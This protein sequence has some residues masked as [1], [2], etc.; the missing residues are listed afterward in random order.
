MLGCSFKITYHMSCMEFNSNYNSAK[1]SILVTV[2][3][4]FI[5]LFP[6]GS[7]PGTVW[8]HSVESILFLCLCQSCPNQ[9]P[10]LN[11]ENVLCVNV[12]VFVVSL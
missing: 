1:D 3:F 6:P 11:E 4:S 8:D 2:F 7:A 12:L 5:S 9:P 10:E